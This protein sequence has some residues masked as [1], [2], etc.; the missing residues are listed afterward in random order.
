ME[1][2][3]GLWGVVLQDIEDGASVE[4]DAVFASQDDFVGL[5]DPGSKFFAVDG[6]Q[7]R[8]D[9]YNVVPQ[10]LL[11][12]LLGVAAGETGGRR[13]GEVFLCKRFCKGVVIGNED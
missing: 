6:F 8:G 4:A 3:D 1:V 13:G 9:L 7:G 5:E 11:G 2:E 10:S 12:N